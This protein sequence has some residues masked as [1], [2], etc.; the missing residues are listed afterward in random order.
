MFTLVTAGNVTAIGLTS[1]LGK[2]D[3]QSEL[4]AE[5]GSRGVTVTGMGLNDSIVWV[6]YESSSKSLKMVWHTETGGHRRISMEKSK[7]ASTG[8]RLVKPQLY[9]FRWG[10][11]VGGING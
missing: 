9:T 8:G 3:H 2:I 7:R 5:I 10:R 11:A 1:C 6:G 4:R